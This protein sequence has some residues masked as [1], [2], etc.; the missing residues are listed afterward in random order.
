MLLL[1]KR[2]PNYFKEKI[3]VYEGIKIESQECRR[4]SHKNGISC[5]LYAT[6]GASSYPYSYD[7]LKSK[8]QRSVFHLRNCA[9][10]VENNKHQTLHFQ[11]PLDAEVKATI[12]NLD[13]PITPVR[14]IVAKKASSLK[15]K[16]V[17]V[18]TF[19]FHLVFFAS[20]NMVLELY[21][22]LALR[23][24]VANEGVFQEVVRIRPLKQGD[25]LPVKEVSHRLTAGYQ[26]LHL[27]YIHQL[28]N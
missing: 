8:Q 10:L 23:G 6:P 4:A 5:I 20:V 19:T 24:L 22:N 9:Q 14:R 12:N 2:Y 28:V 27:K 26:L 18:L 21:A 17:F 1:H 13:I 7:N 15:H 3:R 11:C 25:K 16:T